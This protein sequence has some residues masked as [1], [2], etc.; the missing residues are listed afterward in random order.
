MKAAK[1][2]TGQENFGCVAIVENIGMGAHRDSHNQRNSSNTITAL[3]EFQNGQVWV[4]RDQDDFTHLDEW[5]KVKDDLWKRGEL[6]ELLPG[7][8][9]TF[10]PYKWHMTEPWEGNRVALL[11]YTPR[12]TNLSAQDEEE[13]RGLGFNLPPREKEVPQADSEEKVPTSS[14][15]SPCEEDGE[16]W[17]N[18]LQRLAEDQRDLLE[19][20]QE[21]SVVLRRLLEEEEILLEQYRRVG[22]HVTEEADHTHQV[23]LDMIEQTSDAILQVEDDTVVRSLKGIRVEPMNQGEQRIGDVEQYLQGLTEELQVVIDVP[24]DQVKANLPLWIPSIDKELGALFKDG[25]NGTLR[26]IDLKDAKER[27]R[28]GELTIVPSKLVFTCKP[29]NQGA[30][31]AQTKDQAKPNEPKAKWRRKCR[32]VLCGNFAERPD[33]QSAADLYAAGASA[34]SMRVALVLASACSWVGAGTDI[35]AAFLLAPWPKH[36]RRYAIVPSKTL[37]M[38]ERASDSEAWEVDRALYGLRESPAVWSEFQRLR[39]ARVPWKNGHLYL[40]ASVVDPE[41]WMII[42]RDEDSHELLTGV[43]VTYVDDLLYLAEAEVIRTLHG[44]LCEEWPSSPLEWTHDG[45]RY[46]GVE[47]QQEPEGFFLFPKRGT[48]KPWSEVTIWNQES[49]SDYLAQGNGSSTKTSR[50]RSR[51]NTRRT[52]CVERKRSRANCCG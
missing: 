24:L 18:G 34:D 14:F 15:H 27:E 49:M 29:P 25:D 17:S 44:W 3:T 31:P 35:H 51:R 9:V 20:L 39:E 4:E 21:R 26:R 36:L 5:R 22:Q 11:T 38:A 48:W 46:L 6:H 30:M 42:Y 19:E 37:I 43:L 41:V 52:N 16:P 45:T 40:K 50:L 1:E 47:I 12:L 33:G 10:P 7:R 8:P 32:I 28:R 23:L 13:L 2:I